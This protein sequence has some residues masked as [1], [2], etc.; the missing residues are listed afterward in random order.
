MNK[1][2]LNNFIDLYPSFKENSIFGRYITLNHIEPLLD[3]YS[4][5]F[6]VE[7]EGYSFLKNPIYSIQLGNGKKR[8]LIWTQMHGNES[9]GT[10]AAFDF[11]SLIYKN[12]KTD[13]VQNLLSEITFLI[14]PILNPDGALAYSRLNAQNIDLNRDAVAKEASESQLL[15]KVLKRFH[16]NFCFNL[17]DQRTIFSLEDQNYPA[18]ISL[19]APSENEQRT[20]TPNRLKTMQVIVSIYATLKEYIPN[21]IGRYTDEF[22][23][24]ATGD[25]F[26][27]MGYP[28]ILI[29]AGH[30]KNDYHREMTRKFNFIALLS[31]FLHISD[32][33]NVNADLYF[34]IPNNKKEFFD[35]I[36]SNIII[37]G[38]KKRIGV[39]YK[40]ELNDNY[41]T[42]KSDY[43][44]LNKKDSF[45]CYRLIFK[46]KTLLNQ[47]ELKLYLNE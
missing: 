10:K 22:Y 16:P 43:K 40:E 44:F 41:I 4:N 18:T 1:N 26:Q 23:P 24:T 25:N 11:L 34:E 37:N 38:D 45:G 33:K 19:L 21:Q 13:F 47:D 2:D 27:K 30:Y 17:H 12:Y 14:L 46:K 8:V 29:E 5:H 6:K 42:F 31:A 35:L 9:T 7:I 32:S 3:F 20:I 28:T 36:Y 15:Q 39:T